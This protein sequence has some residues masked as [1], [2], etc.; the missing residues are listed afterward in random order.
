ML[1]TQ[2]LPFYHNTPSPSSKKPGDYNP[3]LGNCHPESGDRNPDSG[4]NDPG[5]ENDR[6]GE[7]PVLMDINVVFMILAEF[8]APMEDI[9]ELALGVEHAM[10]EKPENLG[11]HMKL[12]FIRGHLDR[13]P[14]GHMLIDG[15]ASINIL[16]L[17]LF[18]KLG[19]VEGDLKCTNLSLSSFVGDPIT[20]RYCLQILRS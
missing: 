19:H 9:A 17:S 13:T 12:L 11:A 15:G 4:N 6:Q 20:I 14:I 16:P 2:I 7:E 3:E 8:L 18:K 5:K 1:G 10:V